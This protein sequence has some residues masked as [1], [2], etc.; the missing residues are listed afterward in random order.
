MNEYVFIPEDEVEGEFEESTRVMNVPD[1][2]MKVPN[3]LVIPDEWLTMY[4][5]AEFKP[6]IF[7]VWQH[8]VEDNVEWLV[9]SI[10]FECVV[11][12]ADHPLGMIGKRNI[13]VYYR[14]TV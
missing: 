4:S 13:P 7:P 6:F 8:Y 3:E 5:G 2:L 14:K 1:Y 11:P 9:G 12:D 10:G